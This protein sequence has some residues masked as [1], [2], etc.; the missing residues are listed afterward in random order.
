M[1]SNRLRWYTAGVAV[2]TGGAV[3]IAIDM[4][5]RADD[6]ERAQRNAIASR[7]WAVK[8]EQHTKVVDKATVAVLA[9]YKQV[10]TDGTRTKRRLLAD[11]R[12]AR[13]AAQK[14]QQVSFTPVSVSVQTSWSGPAVSGGLTGGPATSTS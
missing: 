1:R 5:A 11:L 12:R 14:A 9:H 13:V 3:A 6:A 4:N 7:A 8:V 2:L 10:H